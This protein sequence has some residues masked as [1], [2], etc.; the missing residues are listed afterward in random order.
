MSSFSRFSV[1][2]LASLL[3]LVAPIENVFS[4]TQQ[5]CIDAAISRHDSRVAQYNSAYNTA[6]A[7]ILWKYGEDIKIAEDKLAVEL[8]AITFAVGVGLS[9]CNLDPEPMSRLIC[10]DN[11]M[12]PAFIA[13]AAAFFVYDRDLRSAWVDYYAAMWPLY[14]TLTQDTNASWATLQQDY[15][16]CINNN[17]NG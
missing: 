5:Q 6:M 7:P 3:V 11:V 15:Y 9:G 16:A 4:E 8:A 17:N 14:N 1:A 2:V 12:T 13:T 10:I